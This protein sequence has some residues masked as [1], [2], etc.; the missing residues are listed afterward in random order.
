MLESLRII[1]NESAGGPEDKDKPPK[2]MPWEGIKQVVMSV[3]K[4]NDGVSES[5]QEHEIDLIQ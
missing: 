2:T 3:G 4:N 5:L 1:G